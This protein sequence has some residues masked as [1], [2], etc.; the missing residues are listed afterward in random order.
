[1]LSSSSYSLNFS[2]SICSRNT[3]FYVNVPFSLL[4]KEM[5]YVTSVY[6]MT[7][8]YL[9][10]S[11]QVKLQKVLGAEKPANLIYF[12]FP[13][14]EVIEKRRFSECSLPLNTK[15]KPILRILNARLQS[16]NFFPSFHSP[17]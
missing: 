2:A 15:L 4:Y 7:K 1:M 14:D 16:I 12:F 10:G 5:Y 8:V 17:W 11:R 13:R 3:K 9:K 6:S